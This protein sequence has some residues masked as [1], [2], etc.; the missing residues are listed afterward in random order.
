MVS[1]AIPPLFRTL[2]TC[3]QTADRQRLLATMDPALKSYL[4]K[5]TET[6]TKANEDTRADIKGLSAR[7]DS[8]SAR[9][10]ALT[11]WKPDLESRLSKLQETVGM[12]QSGWPPTLAAADGGSRRPDLLDPALDGMIHETAGHGE[13]HQLRGG[14]SVGGVPSTASPANGTL[15][16][17]TPP[18]LVLDN[19]LALGS[20]AAHIHTGLVQI[21]HLSRFPNFWVKTPKSGEPCVNNISLCF[22]FL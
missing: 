15:N 12:L 6:L 13:S 1:V 2:E 9:V 16:F 21:P 5:L 17:H 3:K 22:K 19:S 11:T 4:D 8:Q 10:D 7:I 14:L 18:Q 20:S